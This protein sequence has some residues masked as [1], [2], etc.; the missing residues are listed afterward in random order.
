MANFD[1]GVMRY[2][3]TAAVVEVLFPV[4]WRGNA[5]IACKHC[6]YYSANSRMC[7]LNKKIVNFPER[8]VG[9]FCPLE[10]ITEEEDICANSEISQQAK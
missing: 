7:A 10:E 8:Y 3:K 2:I 4:D 1:S 9:E 6:P 5:E